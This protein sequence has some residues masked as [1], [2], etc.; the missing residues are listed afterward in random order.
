[1][2]QASVRG[3]QAVVILTQVRVVSKRC[4]ERRKRTRSETQVHM[5]KVEAKQG[6]K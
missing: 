3:I 4:E 6:V 5:A 1:M 2:V